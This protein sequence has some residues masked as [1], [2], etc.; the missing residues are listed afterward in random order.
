[1]KGLAI[2]NYNDY[3]NKDTKLLRDINDKKLFKII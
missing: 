1:M 2:K 3:G